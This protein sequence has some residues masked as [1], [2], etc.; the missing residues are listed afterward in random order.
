MVKIFDKSGQLLA[1][2]GSPISYSFLP[3]YYFIELWGASGG[4]LDPGFGAYVSGTLKLPTRKNFYIFIGQKGQY[5]TNA[6]NGGGKSAA[7]GCSGGGSTDIR[8]VNG[9]W[10]DFESLKSR[11]IVAGAGGGSYH[12]DMY[13]SK[14]GD[15]GI[16]A[17]YNGTYKSTQGYTVTIAEGGSQDTKGKGGIGS[18]KGDF[19]VFGKGGDGSV[20]DLNGNGGGSGYFGG[21]GSGTSNCVVGSGAGGSSFVS[22]LDGCKAILKKSTS[23]EYYFSSYPFHYSNLVFTNITARSGSETIWDNNGQARITLLY[24]IRDNNLSCKMCRTTSSGLIG[25]ILFVI[26]K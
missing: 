26:Q 6:Y 4:G 16:F 20:R 14:G 7:H 19:G 13:L 3:G 15:A 22:G 9:N 1:Y 21:G 5:G 8:L 23:T 25:L 10:D 24:S 12:N 2:S 17:G 11:I 18:G